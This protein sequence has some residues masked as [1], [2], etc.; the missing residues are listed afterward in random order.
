MFCFFAGKTTLLNKIWGIKGVRGLFTHT[1]V[2][3]TYQLNEKVFV[4]DFPGKMQNLT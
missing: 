2:P 3:T 1:E 4:V